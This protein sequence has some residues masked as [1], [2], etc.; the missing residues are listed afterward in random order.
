M[1]LN[2]LWLILFFTF[3]L[4]SCA[5]LT[6]APLAPQNQ[7]QS[8]EERAQHLSQIKNW[9]LKGALAIRQGNNSGTATLS[10]QQNNHSYHITLFG[11]LG[12]HSYELTGS[13]GQVDLASSDGKHFQAK[14]PEDLLAEQVGWRL[15]VSNLFYWVRGLP[16][17]NTSA[18]KE[19]DS[20]NH[21][22]VLTQEGWVIQY[23]RYTSVNNIDVPSKIFL[24]YPDLNVKIIINRW[25]FS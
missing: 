18:K 8:W 1:N 10:W 14:N 6:P 4:T 3:C 5:N 22:K 2:K 20:F 13:P 11:P 15:P 17:P 16:S 25:Q 7:S 21:L 19:F 9:S 24:N 12:T 23:L